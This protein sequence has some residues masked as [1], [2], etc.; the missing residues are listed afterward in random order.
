MLAR[1]KYGI[2]HTLLPGFPAV[3]EHASSV[4]DLVVLGAVLGSRRQHL[5]NADAAWQQGAN[6]L[7]DKTGRVVYIHRH[8][9]RTCLFC[10]SLFP[11]LRLQSNPWISDSR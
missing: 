7:L 1:A 11:V 4:F 3:W 5:T 9:V 2:A 8:E 10:L 6:V